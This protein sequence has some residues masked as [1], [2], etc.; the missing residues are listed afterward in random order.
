VSKPLKK[1]VPKQDFQL[2]VY[3]RRIK[4]FGELESLIFGTPTMLARSRWFYSAVAD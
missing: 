2:D 4:F 3:I 1:K